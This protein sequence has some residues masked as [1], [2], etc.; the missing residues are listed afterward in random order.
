MLEQIVEFL[1]A[2]YELGIPLKGITYMRRII[3]QKTSGS[4][5][6]HLEMFMPLWGGSET[7][8]ISYS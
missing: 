2:R 5:Q 4:A 7:L 3:D 8:T 6:R 1:C